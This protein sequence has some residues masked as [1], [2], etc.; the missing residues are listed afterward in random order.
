MREHDL[1]HSGKVGWISRLTAIKNVRKISEQ[2]RTPQTAA[3]DNNA[4]TAGFTHHSKRI[5]SF[6]YVSIAE[7]GNAH[8][9]FQFS[10]RVPVS[11]AIVELGGCARMQAHG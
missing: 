9:L 5:L 6:P 1:K 8:R 7:N 10:D 2:P 4:V 3:A 11:M